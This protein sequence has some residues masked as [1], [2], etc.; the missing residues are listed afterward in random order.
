MQNGL[1]P[2]SAARIDKAHDESSLKTMSFSISAILFQGAT[3]SYKMFQGFP[4]GRGMKAFDTCCD[5][6]KQLS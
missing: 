4:F 3:V 1:W 6:V 2:A 5:L